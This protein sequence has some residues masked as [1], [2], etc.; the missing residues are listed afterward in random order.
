MITQYTEQ[1]IRLIA[2]RVLE[3]KEYDMLIQ[4]EELEVLAF[5]C[6][7]KVDPET[8]IIGIRSVWR[9]LFSNCGFSLYEGLRWFALCAK[10]ETWILAAAKAKGVEI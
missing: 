8:M 6:R 10:P 4:Q 1:Q 5:K 2:A 9:D 3:L 7:D